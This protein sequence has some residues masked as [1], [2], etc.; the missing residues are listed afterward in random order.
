MTMKLHGRTVLSLRC[1][2][3]LQVEN[4]VQAMASSA[5]VDS[6]AVFQGR[7][8]A[9]GVPDAVVRAM[10]IRGWTTIATFAYATTY[11]P[12]SQDDAPLRDGILT[13]LLG[14]PNHQHAPLLRR[15]FFESFTLMS[16]ELKSRVERDPAEGTRKLADP[17]RRARFQ[18]LE[19]QLPNIAIREDWEP[20]HALVDLYVDMMEKNIMAWVP[21]EKLISRKSELA[22]QKKDV[23]WK[24]T[25]P[26]DQ[27]IA[28]ADFGSDFKLYQLL[29][30]RGMS[31]HMAGICTYAAHDRWVQVLM[32]ELHR[33]PPEFYRAVDVSQLGRADFEL[34]T[35]ICE[36]TRDGIQPRAT[37]EKPAESAMLALMASPEVRLLLLPMA[38]LVPP[39]PRPFHETEGKGQQQQQ[40]QQQQNQRKQDR[41][42]AGKP[43]A[44]KVT[45]ASKRKDKQKGR[46][47]KYGHT[48]TP[49]G[50]EICFA[51][52]GDGCSGCDREHVCQKCFGA[53]S[54]KA[55]KKPAAA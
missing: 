31:L 6:K 5:F 44:T 37:G 49:E 48:K 30:R 26:E 11:V 28:P 2:H 36:A 45:K 52:N 39:P 46:L 3:C 8:K 29:S 34:F 51:F 23:S 32:A 54:G 41:G 4:Q 55:C 19:A 17:E 7:A 9:I 38:K 47:E 35:R 33:E 18:Q 42:G 27:V 53:H 50:K 40:Q 24:S 22:G 43:E 14:D 15:L 25:K 20:G 21:W 10:T 1:A 16:A 13:P 12:G